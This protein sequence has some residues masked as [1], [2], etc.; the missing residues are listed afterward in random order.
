MLILQG[1][2][3]ALP[4]NKESW[5]TLKVYYFDN[6]YMSFLILYFYA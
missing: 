4:I 6:A 5:N 3:E 1:R 2:S